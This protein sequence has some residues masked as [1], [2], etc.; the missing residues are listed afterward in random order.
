M[1]LRRSVVLLS[2]IAGLVPIAL[3]Q[4]DTGTIEGSV[5]DPSGAA[6][7][8]VQVS[9]TQTATNFHFT[10]ATNKDGFF[11]VQSLQP[12]PYTV[13]FESPGFKRMVEA[14]LTL[15]VGDVLPVNAMMQVGA[16]TDSVEVKAQAL[17]LET[18]TSVSGTVTEGNTLYKLNMYQRYITN[19]MS[20][21][22]GVT[23][24]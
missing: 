4:A 12:G 24:Q 6:M 23:N 7:P 1:R 14:D 11:R 3:P 18:E 20:I 15:R 21:V 17:L 5:T 22:P 13:A 2:L 10:S 9:I 19:T 8:G 16:V